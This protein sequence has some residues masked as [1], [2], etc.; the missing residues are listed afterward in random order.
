MIEFIKQPWPWYTAGVIIGLIVP[1]LLLL[2]NK[3]FGISSNLRHI[4]AACFPAG[5]PF[6]R[7]NW[8]KEIW[9]FFFVGGI[10]IGAFIASRFLQNDQPIRVAPQ[11]VEE[12]KSYG[13][14]DYNHL[15]PADLFSFENLLK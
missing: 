13:V 7:Y 4:C 3:H 1:A 5:I 15:L 6:F 11:L 14:Q 9:N 10:I 12:L 2:G 8:K